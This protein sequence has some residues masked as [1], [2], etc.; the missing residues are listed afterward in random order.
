MATDANGT[1]GNPDGRASGDVLD[2]VAGPTALRLLVDP[3]ARLRQA[4]FGPGAA[5]A[6]LDPAVPTG[7]YPLAFP[8]Y[9]E[10]PRRTPALRATNADGTTTTRLQVD[11]VE[12]VDHGDGRAEHTIHLVDG[13]QPLAVAL[14]FRTHDDEGVLE[15]WVEVTNRQ[16]APIRLHEVAAASPSFLA[17][18]TWLTHFGGDWAAEWTPTT[19][20]LTLGSKVLETRGGIRPHLQVS[21]YFLLD[22]DGVSSEAAGTVLAGAL[23]WGGDLRFTFERTATRQLRVL[24][25]HNFAQADHVLDPGATYRSPAM[26][27]AW[28]DEGRGELTRRLHRWTRRHV[29]RDGERHRPI[30]ANNW[31]ATSFD[32]D[33]Q[34][35]VGLM[36]AAAGIGAELFLLDD[37]WFGVEHPRD[38][39]TTGLGDWVP[40]PRKLPGG[41][42]PLTRA[43]EERGL[44]FGLWVEPEMANPRSAL[45]AE[46]PDW[47]VGQPGRRGREERQ[48]LVLDILRPEVQRFVVDTVGGLLDANP[49]ITHLKWDANRGITEPGSPTLAPDRQGDLWVDSQLAR[50]AVMAEIAERWPDVELMLCASGGG[51][52]DLGTLRWFHDLWLSDNTDPV[53]RVRMQWAA[54][55]GLPAAAVGAH[56]T[57]WGHRPL[58]FACMVAMSAR[59]GFDIDLTG[60]DDADRG[61]CE[62][63][64]D[65]YK[66]VRPLVQQGDLWRLVSPF[67]HGAAALAYTSPSDGSSAVFCYQLED[68]TV[69]DILPLPH[70]DPE[71]TYALVQDDLVHVISRD[72]R[73]PE[74][75]WPLTEPLTATILRFERDEPVR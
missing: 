26:V 22:P 75:A 20:A 32:F 71:A 73:G 57:R 52:S 21:P 61:V 43:A 39:D 4:G 47:V 70:L 9:D 15:Q 5:A 1:A 63:A 54:T 42:E 25:G 66:E 69:P 72:H 10:D 51:R 29:L 58:P 18:D 59:F 50:W 65:V 16:P 60:L 40:D 35:L 34:R 3:R 41:L 55:H 38:D 49:G 17:G 13:A 64:V 7:L 14:R 23:A 48:Q 56:V 11:D 2:I 53:T 12:R 62:G 31:E 44:R 19:E 67:E 68:G 36:D 74:L 8:A 6:A 37:G 45:L 28:S 27:W 33:E 46:H 24:C 30:V